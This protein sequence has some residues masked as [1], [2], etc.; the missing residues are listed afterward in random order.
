MLLLSKVASLA[1]AALI[2]LSA[3]GGPSKSPSSVSE[4]SV[5][6]AGSSKTPL[7]SGNG[8]NDTCI[9]CITW[10]ASVEDPNKTNDPIFDWNALQRKCREKNQCKF[11]DYVN[12]WSPFLAIERIV[13]GPAARW[14][15]YRKAGKK[16]ACF[17]E[18]PYFTGKEV[19]Y[20]SP[21]TTTLPKELAGQ[22]SSFKLIN[23]NTITV[24][25]KDGKKVTLDGE[26]FNL[27]ENHNDSIIE[28]SF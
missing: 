1:S 6:A 19:C 4:V 15:E 11:F 21:V 17:Y 26:G 5:A 16:A 18:H 9:G 28:V 14:A 20:D 24:T 27:I 23:Q 13:N 3:C 25:F 2:I 12:A 7:Y 22:V 10:W 8:F